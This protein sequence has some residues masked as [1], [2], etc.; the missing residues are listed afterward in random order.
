M[1]YGWVW[2]TR[3]DKTTKQ[4]SYLR[5]RQILISKWIVGKWITLASTESVANRVNNEPPRNPWLDFTPP[6]ILTYFWEASLKRKPCS[7]PSKAYA[8]WHLW[9]HQRR[10]R[11]SECSGRVAIRQDLH[12]VKRSD[13]PVIDIPVGTVSLPV[14]CL[15]GALKAMRKSLTTAAG[16]RIDRERAQCQ[17]LGDNWPGLDLVMWGDLWP[18]RA[19]LVMKTL[20]LHCQRQ[21]RQLFFKEP[22]DLI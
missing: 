7:A 1:V 12:G 21:E 17:L 9:L 3:S 4:F 6:S 5:D 11:T 19:R 14:V 13:C 18:L 2:V 22:A 16:G 15:C 10:N 8:W 20:N